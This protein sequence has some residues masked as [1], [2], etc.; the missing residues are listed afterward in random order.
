M[1]GKSL[2]KDG[3][4]GPSIDRIDLLD[5]HG[6]L[7]LR[8]YNEARSA[9]LYYF[10]NRAVSESDDR[11]ATGQG[12]DQN[13]PEGLRPI[14]W[15]KQGK[16]ASIRWNSASNRSNGSH[17]TSGSIFQSWLLTWNNSAENYAGETYDADGERFRGHGA[18]VFSLSL[19]Q[20]GQFEK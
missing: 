12:L 15:E 10:W 2:F 1:R 5:R 6:G 13:K 17:I 9:V 7:L 11:R 19:H 4:T 20:A 3:P 16:P 14:N 18:T 8:V